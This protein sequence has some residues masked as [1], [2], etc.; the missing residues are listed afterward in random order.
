MS[1]N[2]VGKF[3]SGVSPKAFIEGM[4]KNQEAFKEWY[5]AFT[6]E[7]EEDREFFASLRHRDDLRCLIL[8]AEWCGD[9][10][11]NVPV[12]LRALEET[13]MPTEIMIMEDH[14]DLMDQF[15]TMGGR[16]IPVVI[17]ADTG[18]HVLAQWGPRPKHVQAVM[19]AFKQENPDRT[20]PDY[21]EKIKVAR[22][23]MLAQYGEG[24]G[25]QQVIIQ[26]LRNLLSSI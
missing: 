21:D 16:A 2:V 18:G 19:T 25:Y 7:N 3:R 14:L 4:N 9:V 13:E 20:A 6:W 17:F 24:T 11:R 8:A 23:E 12:V 22:A 10:V 15:L 1:A 26:E 5:Q